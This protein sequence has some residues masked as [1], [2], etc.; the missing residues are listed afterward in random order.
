MLLLLALS[1][2][3]ENV[4]EVNVIETPFQPP[5]IEF[6]PD[7]R[8]VQGSLRGFVVDETEQP[9]PGV[10]V[11]LGSRQTTTD[12]YGHFLFRDVPMNGAGQFVT[13]H[14]AGYFQGSRRFFPL[15]GEESRVKIALLPK[16]FSQ[17]FE[18]SAGGT[19]EANGGA[20]I[21]FPPNAIRTQSGDTYT[22]SVRVAAQWMDPSSPAILEQ[23]PGNLQGVSAQAEEVALATFGMMA[24]ELESPAGEPLNLATGSTATLS[25]PVPAAMQASAPA[26]IPLWSFYDDYGM[27]VEEGSA[28]LQNGRY[29][30]EVSHF[31]FWNCDLPY[32]YADFSAQVVNESGEPLANYKV[33]LRTSNG[34]QVGYDYTDMDGNMTGKLPEGIV[35]VLNIYDVC[36]DLIY[37]E[38]IG[39]FT[40]VVDLGAIEVETTGSETNITGA[41]EN[42]DGEPVENGL[43]IVEIGPFVFYHYFT[44][45]NFDISHFFCSG[46]PDV[47]LILLDLDNE[48]QTD[49]ISLAAGEDHDLGT[50]AVCDQVAEYY[51]N[52]SITSNTGVTTDVEFLLPDAEV[53]AIDS[54]GNLETYVY[55][56]TP[57]ANF[58]FPFQGASVGDYSMANGSH[59]ITGS[60]GWTLT[61]TLE[62]EFTVHEYGDVG[63][64][65]RVTFSG[66]L[67][68]QSSEEFWGVSGEFRLLRTQ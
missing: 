38:E 23:M 1:A 58:S 32:S 39:P 53:I 7:Q 52:V 44:N 12:A 28:R 64:P 16:V 45:G 15:E 2:C 17:S 11:K 5:V 40:G 63:E 54:F 49:L 13:V 33:Q 34:W 47:E 30:G 27:W 65:V 6:E 42:C 25:M 60:G 46:M 19:V 57:Q 35:L 56:N 61:G 20:R 51:I 22:G 14:Q 36:G 29:E 8:L 18:S 21:V 9:M 66:T 50:V 67:F 59:Y 48:Y 10:E 37:T 24:V 26:E 62:D 43:A 55:I 41:A 4:D 68:E 3:R 31:S